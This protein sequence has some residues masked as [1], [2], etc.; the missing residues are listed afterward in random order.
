MLMKYSHRGTQV[1]QM[2]RH[3]QIVSVY[4]VYLL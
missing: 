3:N 4:F 1:F 2:D